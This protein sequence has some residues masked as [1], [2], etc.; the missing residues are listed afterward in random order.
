MSK[1]IKS[2]RFIKK[3]GKVM[4]SSIFLVCAFGRR[5][6]LCVRCQRD[7]EWGLPQLRQHLWVCSGLDGVIVCQTPEYIIIHLIVLLNNILKVDS[8]SSKE[9]LTILLIKKRINKYDYRCDSPKRKSLS[10]YDN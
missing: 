3:V 10:L 6:A 7:R 4:S 5:L 8:S 9:N 1:I 2:L